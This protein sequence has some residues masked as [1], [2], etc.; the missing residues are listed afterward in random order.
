MQDRILGHP[1]LRVFTLPADKPARLKKPGDPRIFLARSKKNEEEKVTR[2]A[3][4]KNVIP[5]ILGCG[6]GLR[7]GDGAVAFMLERACSAQE[8]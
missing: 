8:V 6:E 7:K 1:S 3:E 5:E 2:I 4:K